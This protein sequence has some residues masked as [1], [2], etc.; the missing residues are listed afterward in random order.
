MGWMAWAAFGCRIDCESEPERC[1]RQELFMEMADKLVEDGYLDV[2]YNRIHIDDCWMARSRNSAGELE[3]DPERFPSGMKNLAKYMHDRGLELGIYADYGA[4]TCMRFPGS[5]NREE[6]N[7]L[8][9]PPFCP[10][11]ILYPD[12]R[13]FQVDAKTFASWDIDYLKMD[14]CHSSIDQMNEAQLETRPVAGSLARFKMDLLAVRK[15]CNLW[16]FYDDVLGGWEYI[17]RVIDYVDQNQDML[18]EA[19]QPGAWNDMDMIVAGTGTITPDQARVQMT[20]WSIWSSPLILSNDLR[21]LS[22]EFRE[23]L[24]NE[25]VIGIDQDPLGI[26]GKL[27]RKE[28]SISIYVKPVTPVINGLT[29]FAVAFVN[30]DRESARDLE[31]SLESLGLVNAY[32]YLLRD[33]WMNEDLGHVSPSYVHK[34]ALGPTSASMIKLTIQQINKIDDLS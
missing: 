12:Y 2:G 20:L 28:N 23:I 15:S 17:A 26:M 29:S 33:L 4:A 3:A 5:M 34:V 16:R 9:F 22:Q 7:P 31:V 13:S 8:P 24:Q 14:G 30:M 25:G 27:V 19:Q 1:I 10:I 18:A 32:G 21:H 11:G 6:V